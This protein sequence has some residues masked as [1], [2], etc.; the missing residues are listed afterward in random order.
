LAP[1]TRNT[2]IRTSFAAIATDPDLGRALNDINQRLATESAEAYIAGATQAAPKIT[3]VMQGAVAPVFE[4]AV[5]AMA[6][7][8]A[9]FRATI[10]QIRGGDLS[11]APPEIQSLFAQLSG[12]GSRTHTGGSAARIGPQRLDF[13]SNLFAGADQDEI[14]DFIGTLQEQRSSLLSGRS[15]SARNATFVR[16]SLDL[17]IQA[18]QNLQMLIEQLVKQGKI[19][20]RPEPIDLSD[21]TISR[22]TTSLR[23][24]R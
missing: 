7:Q 22:L 21:S 14:S 16:E 15:G 3:E 10:G 17:Q 24:T 2:A 11:S 1:L 4:S 8:L 18:L 9:G 5:A 20:T 12:Q 19:Q 6:E 23:T 13:L